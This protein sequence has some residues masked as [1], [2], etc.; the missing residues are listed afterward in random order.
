MDLFTSGTLSLI[1]VRIS[2]GRV[3]TIA[4][5]TVVACARLITRDSCHALRVYSKGIPT[6]QKLTYCNNACICVGPRRLSS[7]HSMLRVFSKSGVLYTS[8]TSKCAGPVHCRHIS[9]ISCNDIAVSVCCTLHHGHG[10]TSHIAL[11][12]IICNR[13]AQFMPSDLSRCRVI[14]AQFNAAKPHADT[15]PRLY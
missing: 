5:V 4:E 15:P 12:I 1:T 9:R 7:D 3:I 6:K 8:S 2:G 10:R 13:S 11:C 14:L